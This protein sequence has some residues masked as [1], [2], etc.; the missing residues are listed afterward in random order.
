MSIRHSVWPTNAPLGPSAGW[1]QADHNRFA[2]GF[3]PEDY[4]GGRFDQEA[5]AAYAEA[6]NKRSVANWY[7]QHGVDLG[8]T[9]TTS[10]ANY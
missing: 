10:T 9:H 3:R 8:T 1:S 4:T 2:D 6:R 5:W 7:R